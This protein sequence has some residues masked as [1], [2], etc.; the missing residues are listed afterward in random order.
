[1]EY[2]NVAIETK[3]ARQISNTEHDVFHQA[4][5]VDIDR[6]GGQFLHT[7][8]GSPCPIFSIKGR[9]LRKTINNTGSNE[10]TS[11]GL[12]TYLPFMDVSNMTIPE[13]GE[14][15]WIVYDTTDHRHNIS[16]SK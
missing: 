11:H 13:R 16:L 15:V 8:D 4:I 2:R 12:E 3:L 1:M 9:S 7:R 6:V 14:V 10:V 5:V